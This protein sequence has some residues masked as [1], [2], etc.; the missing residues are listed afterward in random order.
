MKTTAMTEIRTLVSVAVP[1]DGAQK[2]TEAIVRATE[3]AE[4]EA[5]TRLA[6]KSDLAALKADLAELKA[7]LVR[8][9]FGTGITL[10]ALIIGAVYFIV[11][12]RH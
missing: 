6:T 9:M 1:G 8:W 11:N 5:A 10:T 2:L 12:L 4:E 7:D 3:L